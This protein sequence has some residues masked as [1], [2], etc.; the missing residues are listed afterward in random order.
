[1]TTEKGL[2]KKSVNHVDCT[3]EVVEKTNQCDQQM[4][5][6]SQVLWHVRQN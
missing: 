5:L 6:T 3:H 2:R 1:M 4:N